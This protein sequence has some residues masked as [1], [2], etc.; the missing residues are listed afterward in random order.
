[1]PVLYL[2]SKSPR[3][4]EILAGMGI[5]DIEIVHAGPAVL[6]AFEGD[7][8]Q[9]ADEPPEEYVV[10]TASEKARQAM[11][12]IAAEGKPALPVLAAD[13]VVIC[14]GKI[15]GKPADQEEAA[16]FMQRLSGR[17]HEVRTAVVVNDG[18]SDELHVAVSVS[19]VT[20]A[21]LTE[22]QIK[23]Y[24]QTD[25]PYDKAAATPCRGWQVFLS[26]TLPAVTRASWG[27]PSMRRRS[28]SQKLPRS[29][30]RRVRCADKFSALR[31]ASARRRRLRTFC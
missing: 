7:E 10:R 30:F 15:L 18:K 23:A 3:R 2:A 12:R 20:F 22:A 29:C 28:C 9:H 11:Q 31:S 5:D 6:T 16:Q 8:V 24:V 25:E 17:T 21:K 4:K 13:T 27:F 19:Q 26:S 1:M 14:E